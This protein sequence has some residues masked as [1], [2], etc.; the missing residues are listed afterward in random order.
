[1]TLLSRRWR[2]SGLLF[3]ALLAGCGITSGEAVRREPDAAARLRI[4]AV[5]EASGQPEVALSM[6]SAAAAGAPRRGDLQALYSAALA[7]NGDLPAAE[8]VVDRAL[9]LQPE[10]SALL[11]QSAR[12]RL[13]IGDTGS[14][15]QLFD[16]VL[17]KTPRD[18]RA[19]S[20]KGV[21]LDLAGR[22]AEAR[23]SHLAAHAL[24]PED[25]VVT[26][27]LAM[28][29]LLGGKPGEAIVLLEPLAQSR[30]APQR[31]R[32]NLALARAAA[33]KANAASDDL[34]GQL[35]RAELDQYAALLAP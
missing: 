24:A 33:G 19:L 21:A 2:L 13:A 35:R 8:E 23:E 12:N 20:G 31:V 27:N 32:N 6:Y 18:A 28:S 17:A 34:T 29:L 14:A 7:R 5:A 10:D 16:R 15:L 26:N 25:V 22:A 30:S 1:M 3:S 9:A 4:A 11:G